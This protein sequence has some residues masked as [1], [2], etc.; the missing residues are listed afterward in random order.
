[1]NVNCD[2]NV[3]LYIIVCISTFDWA[4]NYVILF[5]YRNVEDF[6]S[7]VVPVKHTH[8]NKFWKWNI[9]PKWIEASFGVSWL[10]KITTTEY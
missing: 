8:S 7:Y 10:C 6:I 2:S 4:Q 5:G 9:E 3:W 1:M